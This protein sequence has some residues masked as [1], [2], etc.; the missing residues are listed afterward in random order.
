MFCQSNLRTDKL[1]SELCMHGSSFICHS[2]SV[3][4]LSKTVLFLILDGDVENL[5]KQYQ[6]YYTQ[7]TTSTLHAG[8]AAVS[9]GTSP[10][11]H[12]NQQQTKLFPQY[13]IQMITCMVGSSS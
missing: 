10:Y 1:Q 4:L 11:I 13:Y 5:V 9:A 3:Y 12:I 6:V 7:K 2:L 8:T